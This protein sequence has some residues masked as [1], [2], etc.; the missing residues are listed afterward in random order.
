MLQRQGLQTRA[1]TDE[2]VDR[3]DVIRYPL[4]DARVW[5]PRDASAPSG[6]TTL[7]RKSAGR[8]LR[9]RAVELGVRAMMSLQLFGYRDNLGA[10]DLYSS[11]PG[12]FDE[13]AES[14]GLLL[15]PHAAIAMSDQ[16]SQGT[17]GSAL[18]VRDLVGGAEGIL[19]ERYGVGSRVAFELLS[20][21]SQNT[22]RKLTEVAWR[23]IETRELGP[24]GARGTAVIRGQPG[25]V[26]A[27]P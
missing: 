25:F 16:R 6:P 2:L 27:P 19:M 12:V 8:T 26:A 15:G 23:L 21:S 9:P 17:L 24:A 5:T 4:S 1:A 22:N 10:L 18:D 13:E 3:V 14:A 11:P 7:P 20:L